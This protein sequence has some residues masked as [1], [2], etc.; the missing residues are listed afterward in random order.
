MAM[1]TSTELEQAVISVVGE[2]K[3]AQPEF[4][5]NA[6]PQPPYARL[7]P[8]T[9][10]IVRANDRAW[11]W[12][13]NYEVILCTTY[14]NRTLEHAMADALDAAGIGYEITF[15]YDSD[16]RVFMAVFYTDPVREVL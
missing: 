11:V 15:S 10:R 4:P 2:G 13:V 3:M 7:M 1:P 9:A 5:P 14:R 12:Q 6:T 8:D 16:E